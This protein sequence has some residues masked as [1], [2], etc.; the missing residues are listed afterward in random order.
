MTVPGL[1][2]SVAEATKPRARRFS[3]ADVKLKRD[4]RRMVDSAMSDELAAASRSLS[5]AIDALTQKE[6]GQ[7]E[8]ALVEVQERTGRLLRELELLRSSLTRPPM[9][10]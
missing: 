4:A 8:Q 1:T 9:P 7:L 5:A 10:S 2:N 3:S 6:W